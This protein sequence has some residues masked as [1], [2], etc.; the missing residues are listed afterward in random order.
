[1][2]SLAGQVPDD[3]GRQASRAVALTRES[4]S[5]ADLK[6][7]DEALELLDKAISIWSRLTAIP[8]VLEPVRK[9]LSESL[10]ER[11]R[12]FRALGKSADADKLDQE[13]EALWKG[14]DPGELVVLVGE[15][16]SRATVIGFGETAIREKG[17]SVRQL[18][19]DQAAANLRLAIELGYS[20][21]ATLRSNPRYT[22]LLSRDDLKPLIKRLET[23]D[24]P[25]R[26][27]P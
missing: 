19:L 11:A 25:T 7:T 23:T 15:E 8:A 20:D 17:Q 12:L 9:G 18:G 3:H 13:R 10:W 14:R 22:L 16:A 4:E 5:L 2:E 24:H 21:I 6:R 26:T 27:G 1:M